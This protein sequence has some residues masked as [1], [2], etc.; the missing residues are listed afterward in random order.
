MTREQIEALADKIDA[1]SNSFMLDGETNAQVL[2]AF[3]LEQRFY[4]RSG[5]R[6]IYPDN[7]RPGASKNP[8]YDLDD[9]VSIYA[10]Y[11]KDLTIPAMI[12][13]NPKDATAFC[14]RALSETLA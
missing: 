2:A 4:E 13:S 10:F 12:P 5:W 9:L 11:R 7:G 8:L 1:T 3:G 6:F 14:L